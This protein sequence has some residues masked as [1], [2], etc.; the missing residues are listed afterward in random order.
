VKF[1]VLSFLGVLG[2][3]VATTGGTPATHCLVLAVNNFQ[4]SD[5]IAY[6]NVLGVEEVTQLGGDGENKY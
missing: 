5:R 2:T 1:S 4:K 3:A 6:P